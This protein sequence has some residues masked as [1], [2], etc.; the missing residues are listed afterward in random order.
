MLLLFAFYFF[1]NHKCEAKSHNAYI[2]KRYTSYNIIQ[3]LRKWVFLEALLDP[4]HLVKR[5]KE[6]KIP[7]PL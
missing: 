7:I 5:G 2:K 3:S 1:H 4:A 6:K